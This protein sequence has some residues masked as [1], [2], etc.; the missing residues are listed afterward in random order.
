[1]VD[2]HGYVGYGDVTPRS[3][4]GRIIAAVLGT[5]GVLTIGVL[6]GLILNWI[7]PRQLD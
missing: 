7:T 3:N 4:E 6:A 1:L 5:M 2:H